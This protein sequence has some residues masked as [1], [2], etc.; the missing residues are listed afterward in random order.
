[1]SLLTLQRQNELFFLSKERNRTTVLLGCKCIPLTR[2]SHLLSPLSSNRLFWR[3]VSV[4]WGINKP[5]ASHL[6][7]TRGGGRELLTVESTSSPFLSFSRT[8]SPCF[9]KLYRKYFLFVPISHWIQISVNS[10]A[11][12][13]HLR[14]IIY[15]FWSVLTAMVYRAQFPVLKC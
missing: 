10:S 12:A 1:M 7:P 15:V 8:T 11:M 4:H 2:V 13:L 6:V 5:S 9:L 14:T 3:V